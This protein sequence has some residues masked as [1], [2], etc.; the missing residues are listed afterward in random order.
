MHYV[1]SELRCQRLQLPDELQPSGA[2]SAFHLSSSFREAK[3]WIFSGDWV[4]SRLLHSNTTQN[5]F[6]AHVEPSLVWSSAF[7]RDRQAC[8]SHTVFAELPLSV[9]SHFRA[10]KPPRALDLRAAILFGALSS[11]DHVLYL[12][13]PPPIGLFSCS[14]TSFGERVNSSRYI[15][16]RACSREE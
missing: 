12:L 3:S 4:D 10:L 9:R 15:S 14:Q 16:C 5:S 11:T 13:Q 2:A 1:A 7:V 8:F 6:S